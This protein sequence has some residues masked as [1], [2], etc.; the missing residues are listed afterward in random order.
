VQ[1]VRMDVRALGTRND[2]G[3]AADRV[4]LVLLDR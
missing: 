4:D 1:S 3:G 2:S